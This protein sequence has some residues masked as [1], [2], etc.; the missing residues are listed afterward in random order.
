MTTHIYALCDP[1][2]KWVRYVGKTV[3]E[4]TSRLRQHLGE[5]RNNGHLR[6]WI[7]K[8]K[9]EGSQPTQ[10]VI[11]VVVGEDWADHERNQIAFHRWLGCDLLN[12]TDG[13]EGTPGHVTSRETRQKMSESLKGHPGAWCGKRHSAET[14]KKM[15]DS[16]MGRVGAWRG[17][18]LSVEHRKKLSD[19][20]RGRLHGPLS[21]EQRK[22]IS[23][24]QRGRKHSEETK[25]KM[26]ESHKGK[27]K[28]PGF[29]LGRKFSQGTLKKLSDANKG[30][31][32]PRFGKPGTM[33]GKH[34]SDEARRKMREPRERGR[35]MQA[36][37]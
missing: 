33:L 7:A 13:G 26:S 6:N 30:S 11:E 20:T 16:Q 17:K 5:K 8:L 37:T 25:K 34:H 19:A 14:R 31:R 27:P 23:D 32:N 4:P 3:L 15:S 35:A 18:H 36:T 24:A 12:M 10:E 2:S 21:S 28:P 1:Q 9:R 22:K 29:G